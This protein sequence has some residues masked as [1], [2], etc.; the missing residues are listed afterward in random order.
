MEGGCTASAECSG[1]CSGSAQ[2]KAN[3]T[4]PSIEIQFTAAATLTAEQKAQLDLAVN[5]IKVNLPKL[6]LVLKA[7]STAF[8]TAITG[9]GTVGV[10]LVRNMDPGKLGVKGVACGGIALAAIVDA[11]ANFKGAL[12]ASTSVVGSFKLGS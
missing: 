8:A 3:C 4:P 11:T 1:S 7:R 2:A 10:S 9:V 5:S 6:L 12:E